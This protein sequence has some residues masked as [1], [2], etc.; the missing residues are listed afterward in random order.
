MAHTDDPNLEA[1]LLKVAKQAAKKP[2]A[3]ALLRWL[4]DDRLEVFDEFDYDKE[5]IAQK[6]QKQSLLEKHRMLDIRKVLNCQL[7]FQGR[8][9]GPSPSTEKALYKEVFGSELQLSNEDGGE[10]LGVIEEHCDDVFTTEKKRQPGREF[11]FD[12]LSAKKPAQAEVVVVTATPE[13]EQ[14]EAAK[15]STQE[16]HKIER[17][18]FRSKSKD[19]SNSPKFSEYKPLLRDQHAHYRSLAC[20]E[21]LGF[22][23]DTSQ[24]R[25]GL[26]SDSK[27]DP[28]HEIKIRLTDLE[29]LVKNEISAGQPKQEMQLLLSDFRSA[30]AR[31]EDPPSLEKSLPGKKCGTRSKREFQST[32]ERSN[33]LKEKNLLGLDRLLSGRKAT[34][35]LHSRANSEFDVYK[36]RFPLQQLNSNRAPEA[37][38]QAPALRAANKNHTSAYKNR[39]SHDCIDLTVLKNHNFSVDLISAFQ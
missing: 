3:A 21:G 7:N 34:S 38:P 36:K 13:N 28:V 16:I 12:S 35:P 14:Q 18:L 6:V 20:N 30:L 17:A 1:T 19:R 37:E 29:T 25:R 2:S 32:R 9:A 23:C 33:L 24:P 5:A 4:R 8:L 31:Y 27:Y 26:K 15:V 11:C 10:N 22:A 39:E